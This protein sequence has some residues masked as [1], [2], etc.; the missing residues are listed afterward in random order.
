MKHVSRVKVPLP[1]AEILI[2]EP[3]TAIAAAV[4]RPLA[5]WDVYGHPEWVFV[6]VRHGKGSWDAV[7]KWFRSQTVSIDTIVASEVIAAYRVFFRGHLGSP[8]HL[9]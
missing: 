4:P 5:V 3:S 6:H 2:T 7:C 9:P 8:A 1:K